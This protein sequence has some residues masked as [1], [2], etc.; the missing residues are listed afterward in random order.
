MFLLGT[1]PALY[2]VST[3]FFI[4]LLI[5][6][7]MVHSVAL[8]LEKFTPRSFVETFYFGRPQHKIYWLVLQD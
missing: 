4:V 1:W 5:T 3:A 7:N 6:L 8:S 2:I